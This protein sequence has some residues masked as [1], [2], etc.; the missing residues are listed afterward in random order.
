MRL[1][2]DT[3]T[4]LWLLEGNS[5]LSP[6]AM[7]LLVDPEHELLL[8][9]ATYWELAIKVSLGKYKLADPISEFIE[10][11]VQLYGL[12]ILPIELSHAEAVIDL[13]FHH[14]D[15]FDRMLIA[16]AMV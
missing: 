15:P 1:L 8:S 2:L 13:P 7:G 16:Q 3:H 5:Q 10:E 11:A 9:P 14:K 12:T 6:L 4:L